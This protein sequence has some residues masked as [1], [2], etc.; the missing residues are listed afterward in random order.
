MASLLIAW[1]AAA[2]TARPLPARILVKPRAGVGREEVSALHSKNGVHV[3][4][5]YAGIGG[6]EALDL[7]APLNVEAVVARYR[8]SPL[9]EYAEPDS[10]VRGMYTPNDPRFGDGSLWNF[11][12]PGTLGGSVDADVD[13]PEAWDIQRDASG[14]IV[15]VIDTGVRY[16]HEDLA[17]NMWRNPIEVPGNR[18]DEDNNGYF[19]DVYGINAMNGL[20]N[21]MDDHGHGTH[22]AGIIGAVGDNSIGCVGVALRVQ[23]MALKFLGT[24]MYGTISDAIECIDYARL[25]GA[26][27]INASWGDYNDFASQALRD[28]IAAAR[29]AG[30]IFVAAA[31]NETGNNDTRPF[32]P[33]SY[34]VDNIISVAATTRADDL[35]GFSC[36]GARTV[37]LAAPGVEVYSTWGASDAAYRNYSGTSMAAPHVAGACALVWARFP[38]LTYREVIQRVLGSVDPL[39]SLAGKTVTGGRLNLYKALSGGNTA[40]V[41]SA[42]PN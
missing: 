22:V 27:V 8:A 21:P 5:R 20:G 33:A 40:P 23:I 31:G 17:A 16:T 28:A 12:N 19:S 29:D 6:L 4:R 18:V 9:V 10:F 26:R 41:L 34:D 38:S 1:S 11:Y 30:I 24:N 39:P 2:Q 32:Y 13:A 15:A 36:F 14:V 35:A 42:I 7:P 37:H 3:H 25:K